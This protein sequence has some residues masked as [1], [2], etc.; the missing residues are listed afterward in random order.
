MVVLGLGIVN[1]S[2]H[3]WAVRVPWEALGNQQLDTLQ[4]SPMDSVAENVIFKKT[5]G[6]MLKSEGE[7]LDVACIIMKRHSHR[8]LPQATLP[9]PKKNVHR[10]NTR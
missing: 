5:S 4:T 7:A 10:K 3:I 2:P 6:A 9:F 1:R 8:G